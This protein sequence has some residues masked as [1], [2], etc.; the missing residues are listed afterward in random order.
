[1]AYGSSSTISYLGAM[2]AG[3]M[4]DG[5]GFR[6][7]T[8]GIAPL[9]QAAANSN[10]AKTSSARV[11][12]NADATT[13]DTLCNRDISGSGAFTGV[14]PEIYTSTVG[15][16][17]GVDRMKAHGNLMFGANPTQMTQT[18]FAAESLASNSEQLAPTLSKLNQGINFGKFPTLDG[19]VYPAGGVFPNYLGTGYPDLQA[20]VT[21]GISTL[22]T[23]ASVANFQLLASDLLNLGSAF[24]IED[25][26]NFGNPGQ[27][28]SAI[29]AASGLSIT[30]LDTVLASVG[31]DPDI[32]YNL[33]NPSYNAIMQTVLNSVTTPELVNNAQTILETNVKNMTSLGDYTNFDKIFVN[34]R[35]VIS[36][37][38]MAEFVE[39]IQAIELGRIDTLA[40]LA[41]YVNNVEPVTLPTIANTTQF[42]RS[43][44]IDSLIAKFL[45]GTGPNS[46][47]T[48]VDIIG[49]LGGVTISTYATE[50]ITVM[51]R[52]Y[53]AGELTAL[54]SRLDELTNGL[55]GSYTTVVSPGPPAVISITDPFDSSTHSSYASFQANKIGHIEAACAALMSRRNVNS[56]IQLAIDAWNNLLKKIY[57]EKN[58]QSRIDMGYDVRNNLSENALSFITSLR[59]NI[60]EYQQGSI[61]NGMVNQAVAE[62]DVGGEYMR[63]YIKELENKQIADDYDIRW[64]AEFDE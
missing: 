20:V 18:F 60:N 39:R 64:R 62:G 48:L 51:N 3:A 30:G 7:A 41:A 36:F 12:T 10:N 15:T 4:A 49:S 22:V 53:T 38:T 54:Q 58:F 9:I 42:T 28:I 17:I 23:T 13:I 25:I 40:E 34:S 33:G 16:G 52:L 44:Y 11:A 27:I 5:L 37:S 1:M 21:N 8:Q 24:N 57:D 50:Y 14:V 46:S 29:S 56:D 47:V 6:P 45:G 2:A 61:I 55:N 31:I 35:D 19:L 32:I 43:D 26:A 59:G 63:A